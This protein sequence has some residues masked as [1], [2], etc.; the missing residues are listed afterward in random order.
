LLPKAVNQGAVAGRAAANVSIAGGFAGITALVARLY[1]SYRSDGETAYDITSIM[2]G[3]MSGL[4]AV[5]AGCGTLDPS[6]SVVVGVIAGLL[7]LGS[8]RLLLHLGIDDATD[9]I[10]VHAF[11]GAWGILSTG[12]LSTPDALMQAYG[13]N[14]HVGW[15]YSMYHNGTMDATLLGNQIIGICFICGFVVATMTPFFLTL[16]YFNWL[17]VDVE[18]EIIGLDATCMH[19]V[20][21]DAADVLNKVHNELR[22]H[23]EVI[24]SAT[25]LNGASA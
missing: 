23:R 10:P 9:G 5:T 2:N 6:G 25:A 21:E 15:L 7:Y 20:E 18:Q 17:R 24:E 1:F 12:L 11:S 16:Q 4:V 3:A 14:E 22:R 13:S 8:S 19:A